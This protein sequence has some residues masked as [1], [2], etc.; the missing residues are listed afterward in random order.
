MEYIL[1]CLEIAIR[2][3]K[4]EKVTIDSKLTV[5]HVLP[6]NWLEHWPLPDGSRGLT[7]EERLLTPNPASERRDQV[8]Q[9]VGNLTLLTGPLNTAN[10]NLSFETKVRQIEGYSLLVLNGYFKERLNEGGCWDES[11]IEERARVTFGL[12]K[13]IWPHPS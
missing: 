6:Q 11:S 10:L 3:N 7:R 5:E 12:A 1:R 9:T 8:L 4:H 13:D 2:T